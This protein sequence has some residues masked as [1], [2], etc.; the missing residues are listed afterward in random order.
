M[1]DAA[2]GA[3]LALSQARAPDPDPFR[4]QMRQLDYANDSSSVPLLKDERPWIRWPITLLYHLPLALIRA[5][6]VLLVVPLRQLRLLS[7]PFR[8][9]VYRSWTQR[10]PLPP[11]DEYGERMSPRFADLPAFL[12]AVLLIC[13][14]L[15]GYVVLILKARSQAHAWGHTDSLLNSRTDRV[16]L[17]SRPL[18]P[19]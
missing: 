1:A 8:A 16:V 12:V 19:A 10:G 13:V 7:R 9:Y 14:L 2:L 5:A 6:L 3:F 18:W 17:M 11:G 15:A 4:H